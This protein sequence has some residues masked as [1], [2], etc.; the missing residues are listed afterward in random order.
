VK[1]GR[2]AAKDGA[3]I[4][5]FPQFRQAFRAKLSHDFRTRSRRGGGRDI[6]MAPGMGSGSRLSAVEEAGCHG[7]SGCARNG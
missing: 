7:A 1:D 6:A 2:F 4:T 3:R 5:E